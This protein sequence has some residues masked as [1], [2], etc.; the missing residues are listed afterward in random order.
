MPENGREREKKFEIE[1]EKKGRQRKKKGETGQINV[2]NK[3]QRYHKTK[4]SPVL[5]K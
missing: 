2:Q 1:K 5:E 4:R 3:T